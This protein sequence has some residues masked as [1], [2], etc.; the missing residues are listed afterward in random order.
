MSFDS[1]YNEMYLADGGVRNHYRPMAEWIAAT[2]KER[3]AQMRQAAHLLFHR[4]GITF[5]VYGEES[6]GERL[7]PF[8][9][10]PHIIPMGEWQGCAS[11]SRRSMPFFMT[12]TTARKS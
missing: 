12:S 4:V 10:L 6:G 2:P 5:A 11:G 1:Y 8:D 7:I 9:M 3:I